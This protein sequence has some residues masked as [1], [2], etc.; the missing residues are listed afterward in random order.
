M[1]TDFL[2]KETVALVT[3]ALKIGTKVPAPPAPEGE[4][5]K[6]ADSAKRPK[7]CKGEGAEAN[8][9]LGPRARAAARK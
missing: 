7:K 1:V 8:P 3:E 6:G 2:G 4:A 5:A 9:R